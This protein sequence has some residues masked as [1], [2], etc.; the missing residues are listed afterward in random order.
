MQLIWH[1]VRLIAEMTKFAV[2][3][4]YYSDRLNNFDFV[5]LALGTLTI[6]GFQNTLKFKHWNPLLKLLSK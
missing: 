2:N 1:K 6:L 4:A 3:I 5:N